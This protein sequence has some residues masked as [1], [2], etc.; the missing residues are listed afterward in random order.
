MDSPFVGRIVPDLDD[1]EGPPKG[2]RTLGTWARSFA[3]GNR[4]DGEDL[5]PIAPPD[6]AGELSTVTDAVDPVTDYASSGGPCG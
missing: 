3:V 6:I 2:T 4:P 1:G 5:E